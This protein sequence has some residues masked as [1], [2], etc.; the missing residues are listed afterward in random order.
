MSRFRFNRSGPAVER[1]LGRTILSVKPPTTDRI[2]RPTGE[3]YGGS[4]R[5][6]DEVPPRCGY[7]YNKNSQRSF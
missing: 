2:V 1:Q 7:N 3:M 4:L 5:L 6:D